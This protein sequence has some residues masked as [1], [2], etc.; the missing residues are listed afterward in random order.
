[1]ALGRNFDAQ[2]TMKLN[3]ETK[4]PLN[5]VSNDIYIFKLSPF[6]YLLSLKLKQT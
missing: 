1:M 6:I 5:V 4:E 2:E 3:H